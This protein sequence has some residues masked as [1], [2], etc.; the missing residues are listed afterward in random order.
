M[1]TNGRSSTLNFCLISAFS[2]TIF[3]S[4][5]IAADLDEPEGITS[6]ATQSCPLNS[7]GPSL[8]GTKWRVSSTYGNPVPAVVDMSMTVN[9][10]TMTGDTGC[11]KYAAKFKQVGYT[12]FTIT[13]M[14]RTRTPC[15]LVSQGEGKPTVH[16]GN[17]EGAYL[18]IMRRM[19]SVQQMD[20]GKLVFY[21]RNGKEGLVM[22]K[23]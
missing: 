22:T 21:D 12:G 15:P 17:L 10:D 13:Q 19:G 9:L 1:R 11:N 5:V 4:P 6:R 20:D 16:L 8:L 14:D 2:A 23:E 7:G 18:R 3:A